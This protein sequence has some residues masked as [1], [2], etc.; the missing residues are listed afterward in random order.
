MWNEVPSTTA[1]MPKPP[2]KQPC[3]HKWIF[4]RSDFSQERAGY[5]NYH[6]KRIDTYF[7]EKCLEVKEIIGKE[8][9]YLEKKP[10]WFER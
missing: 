8:E 6:F 3:E 2:V 5:S 9:S 7:C 10:Y 4:Q 1:P